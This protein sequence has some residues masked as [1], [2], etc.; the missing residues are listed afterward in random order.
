MAKHKRTIS[1]GMITK[2]MEAMYSDV[3]APIS[4]AAHLL[5]DLEP[6]ESKTRISKDGTDSLASED[7]PAALDLPDDSTSTTS[8]SKRR[9]MLQK[10]HFGK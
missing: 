2:E 7:S 8:S 10:L 5:R 3:V 6:H 4:E 9:S 1:Y